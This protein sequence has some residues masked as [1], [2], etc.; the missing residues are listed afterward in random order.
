[1]KIN[2][3][4]LHAS[5]ARNPENMKAKVTRLF[6]NMISFIQNSK[7]SKKKSCNRSGGDTYEKTSRKWL[8]WVQGRSYLGS[9]QEDAIKEETLESFQRLMAFSSSAWRV[10]IG[11]FIVIWLLFINC[12]HMWLQAL[13]NTFCISQQQ[14]QKRSKGPW[15]FNLHG[16]LHSNQTHDTYTMKSHQSWMTKL[17][18]SSFSR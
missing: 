18:L 14:Q 5:T 10:S 17:I 12:P 8:T 7:A 2:E 15:H 16:W 4:Y 3:L 6:Y 13:L 9:R 11:V 1:M